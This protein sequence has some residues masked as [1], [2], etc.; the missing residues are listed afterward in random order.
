MAAT[1]GL[2]YIISQGAPAALT[3]DLPATPANNT[4]VGIKDGSNNFLT[5]NATVKTT[6]SSTIE[7]GSGSTGYTLNRTGQGAWFIYNSGT[8]NWSIAMGWG[9]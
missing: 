6:D 8:T 1:N 4:M 9:G 3:A 7:G 2:L 5:N